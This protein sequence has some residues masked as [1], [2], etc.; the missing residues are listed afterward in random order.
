MGNQPS[1]LSGGLCDSRRRD[2]LEGQLRG[3]SCSTNKG[4]KNCKFQTVREK[5]EAN[6]IKEA[7]RSVQLFERESQT[8]VDGDRLV[9]RWVLSEREGN[10]AREMVK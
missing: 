1:P 7:G 10:R 2:E 4:K 3:E 9:T 6:E 8:S 5:K